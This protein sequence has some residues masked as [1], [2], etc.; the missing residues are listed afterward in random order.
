MSME[1]QKWHTLSLAA[2]LGNIGSE[3]ARARHWEEKKDAPMCQKALERA[4]ALVD[5]TLEDSS[6]R[7]D[8]KEIARLRE[9]IGDWY[10]KADYFDIRH[11]DLEKYC[12]E[13]T[14]AAGGR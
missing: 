5:L 10:A 8:L 7:G 2:Q 3:L 14:L 1:P 4:I 12:I 11:E 13:L 6:R 9:V